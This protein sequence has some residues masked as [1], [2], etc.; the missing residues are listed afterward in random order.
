MCCFIGRVCDEMKLIDPNASFMKFHFLKKQCTPGFIFNPFSLF[1][2]KF[3]AMTS[4]N[5]MWQL[6][7]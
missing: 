2:R 5:H 1:L 7:Y 4:K 6:I 3:V